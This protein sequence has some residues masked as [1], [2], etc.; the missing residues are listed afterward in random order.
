[1]M[2]GLMVLTRAA[3]GP[4]DGLGHHPQRVAPLGQLV[5]ME[6]VG[7]LV[8]LE[9]GQRQQRLGWRGRQRG[10]LLGGQGTQTVPGLRGDDDPGAATRDDVPELLEQHG[11]AVQVHGQDHRRQRLAG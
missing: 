8:R 2:P 5:G 9:H 4:P 10:V 11:G 7:H 3:L 1:M 6:G